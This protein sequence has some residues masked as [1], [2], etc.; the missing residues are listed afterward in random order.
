ML[1]AFC[2]GLAKLGNLQSGC[3]NTR[4][5]FN[6]PSKRKYR[7]DCFLPSMLAAFSPFAL[8]SF[9]ASDESSHA[10]FFAFGDDS[11][12]GQSISSERNLVECRRTAFEETDRKKIFFVKKDFRGFFFCKKDSRGFFFNK[13]SIA[14]KL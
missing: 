2:A 3:V 7:P 13:T 12:T 10:F 9:P 14:F 8:C 11:L 5:T 6:L 1:Q 4:W